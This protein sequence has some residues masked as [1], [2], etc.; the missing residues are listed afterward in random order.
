MSYENRGNARARRN[1]DIEE[2]LVSIYD[3]SH[4]CYA[5]NMLRAEP[6]TAASRGY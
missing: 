6:F 5:A 2:L 3:M 4:T 1:I